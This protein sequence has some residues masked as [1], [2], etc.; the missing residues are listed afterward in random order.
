M[1]DRL[2]LQKTTLVDYPGHVAATL[3]THG[4]PLRCPY[5]HN[6]ELIA[7]PVPEHFLSR[8]E[9]SDFLAS[10]ARL[11]D[12]VCITGGEPL[13]HQ[14]LAELLEEIRSHGLA[15]KLDTSGM[16]PEHLER[17]LTGGLVDFVAV[18][19]KTGPEHY[20]RV[21][22]DGEKFLR[23]VAILRESG[24]DYELRTT[25]APGVVTE[26]DIAAIAAELKPGERY[27]LTQFRPGVT[28]DPL[29]SEA[30]PYT[31]QT[32]RDWCDR[33][34]ESGAECLLRGV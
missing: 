13:V 18:D 2:G 23:A 3:F 17:L 33:I 21:G 8:R 14:D 31:A 4:C 27:V 24:V 15:V 9:I 5:C 7:G 22:G 19:F 28:L 11:L 29:Q 20:D 30:L 1:L 26:E 32:L 25:A 12:G 6:P 10:R 34:G 16:F